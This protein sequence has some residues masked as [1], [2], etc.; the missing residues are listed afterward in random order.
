MFKKS[1]IFL[2]F[3]ML[4][5]KAEGDDSL[6][7]YENTAAQVIANQNK[8]KQFMERFDLTH[9]VFSELAVDQNQG[10]APYLNLSYI[11]KYQE[12]IDE[13]SKDPERAFRPEVPSINQPTSLE[14]FHSCVEEAFHSI[15]Y[16]VSPEGVKERAQLK[17]YGFVNNILKLGEFDPIYTN[18]MR[19][20]YFDISKKNAGFYD[21]VI[22]TILDSH[23]DIIG[24]VSGLHLHKLLEKRLP[25]FNIFNP[26]HNQMYNTAV[27]YMMHQL[28]TYKSALDLID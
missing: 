17:I 20:A 19:L 3:V 21:D 18:A 24:N 25:E 8:I 14:I 16:R 2:F 15:L 9:P 26:L 22:D 28:L 1:F 23:G 11:D 5:L 12:M 13:I 27:G 6:E 4:I 10:M 7:I